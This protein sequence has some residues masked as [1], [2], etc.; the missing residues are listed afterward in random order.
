MELTNRQIE[1]LAE[2]VARK[3]LAAISDRLA[4]PERRWLSTR[5]ACAYLGCHRQT[6]KTLIDA[7]H[8]TAKK[9][10]GKWVI[11]RQS[12]DDYLLQDARLI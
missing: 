9:N 4:T 12:I 1:E 2:V 5:E 10:N 6:L 3:V 8:I 7:G 11:C